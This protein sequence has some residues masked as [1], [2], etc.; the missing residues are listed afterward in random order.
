MTIKI[1]RAVRRHLIRP[2]HI[3]IARDLNIGMLGSKF[4]FQIIGKISI[5]KS[6]E[7]IGDF[8][9]YLIQR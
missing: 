5:K 4:F 3:R 2:K 6:K 8:F 1:Q 9:R 7:K